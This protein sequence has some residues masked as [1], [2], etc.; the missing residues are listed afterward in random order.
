MSWNDIHNDMD[1]D[2]PKRPSSIQSIFDDLDDE[3]AETV[4][5]SFKDTMRDIKLK[6]AG[7]DK[8]TGTMTYI[9]DDG[10]EKQIKV[11]INDADDYDRA[12]EKINKKLTEKF[13]ENSIIK[14]KAL[15][16][17]KK[18]LQKKKLKEINDGPYVGMVGL[19]SRLL[20]SYPK[21]YLNTTDIDKLTGKD[22]EAICSHELEHIRQVGRKHDK[23]KY[24]KAPDDGMLLL[25]NDDS[26]E[27]I[28]SF[29][30]DNPDITSRLS[31]YHDRLLSELT[32]DAAAIRRVGPKRYEKA[33]RKLIGEMT[34]YERTYDET[35]E[36]TV[37]LVKDMDRADTIMGIIDNM[38]KKELS[39][40]E[41][42]KLFKDTKGIFDRINS[43]CI[44]ILRSIISIEAIS[45]TDS[46]TKKWK[47]FKEFFGDFVKAFKRPYKYFKSEVGNKI[48]EELEPIERKEAIRYLYDKS[49]KEYIIPI[50]SNEYEEVY[51]EQVG[52]ALDST[53]ARLEFCRAYG[54]WYRSQSKKTVK[55]YLEVML[56]IDNVFCEEYMLDW[57]VDEIVME[58]DDYQDDDILVDDTYTETA[59]EDCVQEGM[60][61]AGFGNLRSKIAQA[62][63]EKF[64]VTNIVKGMGG[65]DKFDITEADADFDGTKTTV[66][67]T[68][69]GCK[70]V[71]RGDGKF[72]CHFTNIPLSQA[73]NKILELFEK[74]ELLLEGAFYNISRS[75][76]K[77][78]MEDGEEDK[79]NDDSNNDD[80]NTSDELPKPPED[81]SENED[82]DDNSSNEETTT[83]E[84]DIDISSFGSDT[85]DV[86]NEY[87][88]GDI[89]ILN[90]LIASENEAINDYFDGTKDT[91]DE[92]L[93]TLYGDIG[94]E[95]RF[96][97][98]Q[99]L[100]A[101]STLTG[102]KYEP[103][104][105]EVK[106]EYEEL[107]AGGMDEDTAAS[108][109][110]DKTSVL[111]SDN[112]D[113]SDI[114]ELEQEAAL[115]ET[116]L[117]H[118]EI[119]TTF[120]ESQLDLIKGHHIID[121]S[122][123]VIME[124][125]IQEEVEN[126]TTAPKQITR[127]Q[128]PIT[129]LAKG[130]KASINGLLRLSSVIRDSVAKSKVKNHRKYEWIKKH[131]IGELFKSGISLYF[132]SDK[133][134]NM[135][136][137][138]PA[139]YVD[140]MYRLTKMIGE[141]C[142]IKLTAAANHRTISN[143]IMF[144]NI[145]EGLRKLNGAILTPTKVVVTDNNRD[146]LAREFFGYS[147]EKI[148]VNVSH[149]ENGP[150]VRDSNNIYNKMEILSLTTKQYCDV[151]AAVLEQLKRFEGD[152]NSIYY[153][154]RKAYNYAVEGMKT[155][156]NRYN[157][158]IKA[159]AHD[160]KV[161]LTLDNGLLKMTRERDAT[162]QTGGKWEGADV[163]VSP[164]PNQ[165]VQYTKRKRG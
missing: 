149:G 15:V 164:K 81:D 144:K 30:K 67:S 162:E 75:G 99:L 84:D 62:L 160:L 108:T 23:I 89:E 105:P 28:K 56:S 150:V 78:Y 71:S 126:V 13:G 10:N 42:K 139:Q 154:N 80:N 115:I 96:H 116:M 114:E 11:V 69:T 165:G 100:Y 38:D 82:T 106:K 18:H 33:L 143:P 142:G 52:A 161:M 44:D 153:K 83:E 66:E 27:F 104:D 91:K 94:H 6:R 37:D 157:Q 49:L 76:G 3:P 97:L 79:D 109:A 39:D 146:A 26:L 32:A 25:L 24:S 36:A 140:M 57:L 87:D 119:L 151:A 65:K 159:M 101:K 118:N 21:V 7:Y 64:K 20:H 73:L 51:K 86:Q 2:D 9:D 88:P 19:S 136:F 129:L 127:I 61:D 125:F 22:I 43:G 102:E 123:N 155:V 121:K 111:G 16:K 141:S 158:F 60:F 31:P 120:C 128:D 4:Q 163:R 54:A 110:I 107:I 14:T 90:K 134:S 138:T 72:K 137:N 34:S 55:E 92:N 95:E 70:V 59:Q 124:S 46:S 147:N 29:M 1:I 131:G 77:L 53:K 113:D 35:R 50:D 41:F 40:K 152:V 133:N 132:Y 130:L 117:V 45:T 93:R 74:P 48:I 112:G 58:S 12:I 122:V 98:E 5:E 145:D 135:D 63:G 103:R 156:V 8:K 85:S 47:S 17:A 68:G 148:P